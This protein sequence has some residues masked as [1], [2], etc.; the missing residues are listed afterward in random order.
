MIV[1]S[2]EARFAALGLALPPAAPA[3][4]N[5]VPAVV[6]GSLLIVSGQLCFG[7]DGK[8]SPDHVGKVRDVVSPE[9][10]KDA[11]RLA[12]LNVIAQAR[13]VL[14]SLDRVKRIVRLGGMI[15]SPADFSALPP[16][17]NGASDL[18]VELFGDAGRHARTTVGMASLPLDAVIE[19]E[20]MIEI[21]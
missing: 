6:T 9:K 17:M 16:I 12:G 19:V 20:A 2:F 14:G 7:L 15:N 11:A 3:I 1:M 10:A 13:A 5:Y 18:M 8:L 4:A 21:G